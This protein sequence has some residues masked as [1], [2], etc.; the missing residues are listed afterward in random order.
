MRLRA[1][2]KKPNV[3]VGVATRVWCVVCNA[4]VELRDVIFDLSSR[5]AMG[6]LAPFGFDVG[7]T[8]GA[9]QANE[10]CIHIS[11]DYDRCWSVFSQPDGEGFEK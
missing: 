9:G 2:R 5:Q 8:V 1:H 4:R 6:V 10:Q 3:R 7:H 11:L